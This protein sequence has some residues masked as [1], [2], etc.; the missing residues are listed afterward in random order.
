MPGYVFPLPGNWG[1]GSRV[2]IPLRSV[3]SARKVSWTRASFRAFPGTPMVEVT[4][5]DRE[6]YLFQTGRAE[7][8]VQIVCEKIACRSADVGGSRTNPG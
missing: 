7:E 2:D 3:C 1:G 6:S 8:L 5:A 4:L